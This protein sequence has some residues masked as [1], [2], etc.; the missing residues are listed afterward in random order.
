[1][2]WTV[3]RIRRSAVALVLSSV[4][5]TLA[6][7]GEDEPEP[8]VENRP[9]EAETTPAAVKDES[10]EEFIRRWFEVSKEMQNTGD[11]D[12][13]RAMSAQC[14]YCQ[15]TATLIEGYYAAGGHVAFEGDRIKSIRPYG[16]SEG[17]FVVKTQTLPTE[18][19]TAK[20]AEVQRFEGGMDRYLVTLEKMS[21]GW[22]VLDMT[23]LAG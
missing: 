11:T 14:S 22:K 21:E 10:P 19:A 8:T 6:A 17:Q 4:V 18:Y 15:D 9:S 23:S 5:L 1:M 3:H 12:E 20:G 16:K 7:C 2:E 13:Y